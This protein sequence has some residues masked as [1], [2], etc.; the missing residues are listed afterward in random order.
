M[1]CHIDVLHGLGRSFQMFQH[2]KVRV[3]VERTRLAK[4]FAIGGNQLPRSKIYDMQ[5]PSQRVNSPENLLPCRILPSFCMVET[6]TSHVQT[7]LSV[8]HCFL[9]SLFEVASTS[10]K[11]QNVEMST[12]AKVDSGGNTK[13]LSQ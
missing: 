1:P 4:S 6:L 12:V 3:V 5:S 7:I 10:V 9:S 11:A 2:S 8:R 13:Q